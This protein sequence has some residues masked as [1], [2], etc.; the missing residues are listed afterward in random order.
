[1]FRSVALF[2][3]ALAA[4]AANPSVPGYNADGSPT[5]ALCPDTHGDAF[6]AWQC[7]RFYARQRINGYCLT[8]P[9]GTQGVQQCQQ[10]YAGLAEMPAPVASPAQVA[11][12]SSPPQQKAGEFPGHAVIYVEGRLKLGDD[13]AL[14]E[15]T[16]SMRNVLLVLSG[17]GGKLTAGI[18]IGKIAHQRGW[19]TLV[20]NEQEC[21]SACALAWL[22][23][24][25]RYMGGSAKI[26]FHAS[27][28]WVAG[29][30]VERGVGNALIGA[31]M[32]SLGLPE[33]AVIAATISPPEQLLTIDPAEM[34]RLGIEVSVPRD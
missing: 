31:Y 7:Q 34:R 23:G 19:D 30:Q 12:T 17:P 32:N 9:G 15:R 1:M 25:R 18:G 24:H 28:V 11:T 3:L 20:E 29:T 5:L 4:C 22:G 6:A 16:A 33:R 2:V 14:A 26:G 8:V 27:Y 10:F 13:E 21:M